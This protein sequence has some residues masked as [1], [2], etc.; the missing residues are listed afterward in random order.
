MYSKKLLG[1]FILFILLMNGCEK[2]EETSSPTQ[3]NGTIP[4]S[5]VVFERVENDEKQYEVLIHA[6]SV[7][8]SPHS[9]RYVNARDGLNRRD[10][11]SIS[12]TILGTLLHGS[13]IIA[14][15]RSENPETIG[16]ITAYWYLC[17]S[18]PGIP[19]QPYWVFG[20]FLS[21]TIPEDVASVLGYWDTDRSGYWF[22]DGERGV[23]RE[24]W[25]FHP[26]YTVAT[27]FKESCV[28]FRGTWALI[29]NILTFERRPIRLYDRAYEVEILEII[30]EV[31]NRDRIIF[32][33]ADG[34]KEV[35]TR[36]ND[37]I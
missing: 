34:T 21:T 25:F 32:H 15:K 16:G 23:T 9:V 1:S 10:S 13:R 8:F 31:I 30:V 7:A 28:G 4:E 29:D 5:Y 27:G 2:K 12:G 17:R 14:E 20:G 26:D 22:W 3:A 19:D 11:P 37:I 33:F 6:A 24:Y 36:N 18:I 35:L